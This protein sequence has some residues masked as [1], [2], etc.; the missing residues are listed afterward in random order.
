MMNPIRKLNHWLFIA[1]TMVFAG[2][3]CELMWAFELQG[4]EIEAGTEAPL[5]AG[6]RLKVQ[7][8]SSMHLRAGV[9]FVP[10]FY[11]DT[12]SSLSGSIGIH[13]QNT[14]DSLASALAGSVALDLRAAYSLDP[15]GGFYAEVGY[16]FFSGGS[17]TVSG[18]V[19]EDAQDVEY[20]FLDDTDD[21]TIEGSFHAVSLHIG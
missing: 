6:A 20:S 8:P 7:L 18:N 16:M 5:M 21:I 1:A 13:G 10:E 11:S 17:G 3:S 19:A 14:A 2:V 4:I 9:G 15:D 12:Y